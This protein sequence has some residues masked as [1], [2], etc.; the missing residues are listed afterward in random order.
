MRKPGSLISNCALF[1]LVLP[2]LAGTLAA[3]T[4]TRI[5]CGGFHSLFA[6]SDGTLWGTGAN[7]FGQLGIGF[8]PSSTNT[9]QLIFSG[10]I[11]PMAAGVY[12]SLFMSGRG[13]WVMGYNAS[14]QLGDGSANVNHFFPEKVVSLGT[15]VN[16]SALGAGGSH[17]LY[18]SAGIQ[19][20]SSALFATGDGLN[21][22]LGDGRNANTNKFEQVVQADITAIAGGSSHTLFVES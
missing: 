15:T 3:Q 1:F 17:S 18:G 5:A 21:G 22:Q 13:L 16:F 12:H 4:V 14:G 9:P 2:L 10:T 7:T 19:S 11:G 8:S 6:K 20:G